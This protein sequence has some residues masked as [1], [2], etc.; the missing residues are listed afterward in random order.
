VAGEINEIYAE[1]PRR[2]LNP[3]AHD[4]G[5]NGRERENEHEGETAAVRRSRDKTGS[6]RSGER[7]AGTIG[8]RVGELVR[9]KHGD[10]VG[11]SIASIEQADV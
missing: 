4:G 5:M 1:G 6:E 3:R 7:Q 8:A 11:R 10:S 2:K 9:R